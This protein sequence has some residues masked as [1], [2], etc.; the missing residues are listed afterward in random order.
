MKVV[1]RTNDL[2]QIKTNDSWRENPVQLTVTQDVKIAPGTVR[3]S[4]TQKLIGFKRTNNVGKK[5][6]RWFRERQTRKNLNLPTSSPLGVDFGSKRGFL[7]DLKSKGEMSRLIRNSI[8]DEKYS[9]HGSLSKYLDGSESVKIKLRWRRRW[10]RR[11]H[12]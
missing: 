1:E 8:M 11:I 2:R 5:R 10:M 4:P 3:N 12:I 9:P 6:V 7:N